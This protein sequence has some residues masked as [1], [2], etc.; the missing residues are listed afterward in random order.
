M[1]KNQIMYVKIMD[2]S[3]DSKTRLV[4][5]FAYTTKHP[6]KEF[7]NNIKAVIRKP[8]KGDLCNA[9]NSN[10]LKYDIDFGY[11]FI[12]ENM[13]EGVVYSFWFDGIVF[14]IIKKGNHV[15]F[16]PTQKGVR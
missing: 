16:Y 2:Y 10:V 8:K 4:D 5:Q 13:V 7:S 3:D 6:N 11:S 1:A 15:F 14:D 9:H 12:K